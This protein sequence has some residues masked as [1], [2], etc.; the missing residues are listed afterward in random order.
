MTKAA[1]MTKR[2]IRKTMGKIGLMPDPETKLAA[3]VLTHLGMRISE[4]ARIDVK[5]LLYPSGKI[6][7]EV[8]LPAKICKMLKPRTMWLWNKKAREAI[9][10]VIDYRIKRKWGLSLNDDR[11]QGLMPDSP[12]LYNNRGRPYSLSDKKRTMVD[13]SINIYKSCD[14]LQ[15]LLTKI[16]KRCGLHNCSSHSGRKSLATNAAEAGVPLEVIARLLGHDDPEMSLHY[17][18]IR[19]KQLEKCYEDAFDMAA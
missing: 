8:F 3:F 16:Y 19:D 6:R 7:T 5:T 11:Y 15:D 12:L 10:A 9:Q 2:E 18:D 1:A 4:V 17:I 14:A 13:G